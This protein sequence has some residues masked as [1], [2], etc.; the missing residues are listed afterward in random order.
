MPSQNK[1]LCVFGDSHIGS[2]RKAIGD[3][4]V[5]L[6]GIDVEFW[7]AT[8]ENFR[9]INLVD[10]AIRPQSDEAAEVLK[11]INA[12]GRLSIAP[13]DFD[14]VLFY[15]ARL[16]LSSFVPSLVHHMRK[17]HG[18]MS[19]AVLRAA[20]RRFIG[21]CRAAR[22]AKWLAGDGR[23]RVFFAPT[24]FLTWGVLDHRQDKRT[25]ALYPEVES[26]TAEERARL[27]GA[28]SAEMAQDGVTLVP[29]P[30]ETVVHGVFTDQKYAVENAAESGDISHKS[31]EFAALMVDSVVRAAK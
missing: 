24:P 18:Y 23:T 19:E 7:G 3:G 10:D 27:I 16:R 5:K 21:N 31:A 1:S 14:L 13:G 9:N 4:K 30:E 22:L 15:G 25:L 2:V 26:T 6:R 28:L 11:S 29:Q 20:A 8:G 17:P 12:R